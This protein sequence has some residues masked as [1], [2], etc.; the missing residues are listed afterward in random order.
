MNQPGHCKLCGSHKQLVKAHIIPEFLYKELYNDIHQTQYVDSNKNVELIKNLKTGI[1]DSEILCKEC[2]GDILNARYDDYASKAL[3]GY[4]NL[5]LVLEGKYLIQDPRITWQVWK[6]LDTG[7]LKLFFLSVLWRASVTKKSFFNDVSLGSL[8]E[9]NIKEMLMENNP[10]DLDDYPI[11]LIRFS[12][13]DENSRKLLLQ[14]KKQ[15][16]DGKTRYVCL[17]NGLLV[18]W[19]ISRNAYPINFKE[20]IITKDKDLLVLNSVTQDFDFIKMFIG[21]DRTSAN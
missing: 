13:K 2:D 3:W 17:M 18:V 6:N 4:K 20:L 9:Q 11:L 1:W 8:H 15:R 14:I 21:K 10:G 7:R 19:H 12:Q 16:L 5:N